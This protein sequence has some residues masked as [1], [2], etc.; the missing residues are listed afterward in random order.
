MITGGSATREPAGQSIDDHDLRRQ[1]FRRLA[2]RRKRR[3]F[4]PAIHPG[5]RSGKAEGLGR[6]HAPPSLGSGSLCA[7]RPAQ[8][9]FFVAQEH[10]GGAHGKYPRLLEYRKKLSAGR[11]S[12]PYSAEKPPR[13][14]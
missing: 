3:S 2:V 11:T 14:R 10:L 1:E 8:A 7:A 4:A 12:A 9:A 5:D 13:P 6:G